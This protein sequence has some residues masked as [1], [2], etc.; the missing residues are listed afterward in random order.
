[1]KRIMLVFS[2]GMSTCF[3]VSKMKTEADKQGFEC[4][5]DSCCESDLDLYKDKVDILLLAPQVKFLKNAISE[6]FNNIPVE[7]ISSID[8]GT[9]NGVKVFNQILNLLK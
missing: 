1:M 4:T 7:V 6:K 3:L 8:Y 2:E 5:I 9:M